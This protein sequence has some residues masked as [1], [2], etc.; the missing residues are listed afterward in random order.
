MGKMF[1]TSRDGNK[2]MAN[3]NNEC[4]YALSFADE[5]EAKLFVS[6]FTATQEDYI[7]N[8]KD[9]ATRKKAMF[10]NPNDCTVSMNFDTKARAADWVMKA[11]L[12]SVAEATNFFKDLKFAIYGPMPSL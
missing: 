1:T 6:E 10:L 4:T 9:K 2:V 3:Y 8:G 12:S 7:I 5:A 11:K